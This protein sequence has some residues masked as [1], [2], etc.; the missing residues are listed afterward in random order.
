MMAIWEAFPAVVQGAI[1]TAIIVIATMTV[2]Y[3]GVLILRTVFKK[4][5]SLQLFYPTAK[6]IW[7]TLVYVAAFSTFLNIVL[8][9]STAAFF[10]SIGVSAVLIGVSAQAFV[11]DLIMGMV[12]LGTQ[13]FVIGDTISVRNTYEG[14]VDKI[15]I[16]NTRLITEDGRIHYIANSCMDLVTIIARGE[17]GGELDIEA[18]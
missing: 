13:K 7:K 11:R 6:G 5:L 4:W 14:V 1:L 9:V 16:Q 10:A 12:V 3:I 2:K 17:L 15:T 8:G 18:E